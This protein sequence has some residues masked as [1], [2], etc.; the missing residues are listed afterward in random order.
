MSKTRSISI[1][2]TKYTFQSKNILAISDNNGRGGAISVRPDNKRFTVLYYFITEHHKYKNKEIFVVNLIDEIPGV[3]L[4]FYNLQGIDV[5]C[6]VSEP[7]NRCGL[8]LLDNDIVWS[9]IFSPHEI[10]HAAEIKN[11]AASF[12]K[13]AR[14]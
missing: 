9:V 2:D 6:Q 10:E 12:L 3:D 7:H 4:K 11:L 1:R 5:I 13:N 8:T 14:S